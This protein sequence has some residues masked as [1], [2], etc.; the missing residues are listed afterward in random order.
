MS[1]LNNLNDRL[2]VMEQVVQKLPAEL[3]SVV[4]RLDRD[5]LHGVLIRLEKDCDR[6]YEEQAAT[7]DVKGIVLPEIFDMET[8]SLRPI[9]AADRDRWRDAYKSELRVLIGGGK[10]EVREASETAGKCKTRVSR[11]VPDAP[12]Q[13][14]IILR[15]EQY[16]KLL[17]EIGKLIE[18]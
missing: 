3:D 17:G 5:K 10:V 18:D 14:Y 12:Q 6:L 11:E 13:G 1:F 4:K 16:I 15:W 2:A 8:F 9:T 7:Q